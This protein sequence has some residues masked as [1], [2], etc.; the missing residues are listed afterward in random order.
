MITTAQFS[1]SEAPF[2]NR[3]G[4]FQ[5]T[6]ENIFAV[7]FKY[8]ATDDQLSGNITSYQCSNLNFASL[9]FSPH[10][11]AYAARDDSKSRAVFISLQKSGETQLSQRQRNTHIKPGNLF[12]FDP[13]SPFMLETTKT[14]VYS[15]HIPVSSLPGAESLIKQLSGVEIDG[16]QGFG[17]L[18]RTVL[19]ELFEIAPKLKQNEIT[20]ISSFLPQLVTHTLFTLDEVDQHTSSRIRTFHMTRIRQ[21]IEHHVVEPDL[22]VESIAK[23]VNLSKRYIHQ[24]FAEEGTSVMKWIWAKRLEGCRSALRNANPAHTSISQIAFSWGFNN[25]AHFSRCFKAYFGESPSNMRRKYLL[26]TVQSGH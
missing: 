9:A 18:L 4:L 13:D 25:Q 11:A 6:M 7:N 8:S 16:Q 5:K 14:E 3:C 23:G 17:A 12:I 20:R 2:S 10:T 24:L 1:T 19:N 15:L 22:S 26:Q 21:Y